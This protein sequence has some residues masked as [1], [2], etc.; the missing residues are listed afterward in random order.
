MM[1]VRKSEM[2]MYQL[3]GLV[4]YAAIIILSFFLT[5]RPH[6]NAGDLNRG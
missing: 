6:H 2:C 4:F 3:G 1:I 5:V